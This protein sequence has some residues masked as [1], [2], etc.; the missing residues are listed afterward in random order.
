MRA[1][2]EGR[3]GCFVVRSCPLRFPNGECIES[4]YPNRTRQSQARRGVESHATGKARE[5]CSAG[6]L[7][8]E[9]FLRN[10]SLVGLIGE[11]HTT[12]ALVEGNADVLSHA[13]KVRRRLGVRHWLRTG[14]PGCRC[15]RPRREGLK[16]GKGWQ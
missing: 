7:G 1:S 10:G 4:T 11:H 2:R 3:W 5:K 15:H 12:K 8:S 6:E 14:H 13:A 9:G 16:S